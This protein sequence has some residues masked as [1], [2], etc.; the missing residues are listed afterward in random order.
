MIGNY[1]ERGGPRWWKR[2][3]SEVRIFCPA[4]WKVS[5]AA[6]DVRWDRRSWVITKVEVLS[7]AQELEKAATDESW[8]LAVQVALA[9]LSGVEW[10]VAQQ[11]VGISPS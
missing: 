10:P 3:Q 1:R 5:V 6:W 4:A 2:I 7:Q 8:E 11:A 9:D